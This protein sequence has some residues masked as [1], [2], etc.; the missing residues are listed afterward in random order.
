MGLIND[1]PEHKAIR[2]SVAGIAKRYG[3]GY[4][5]ERARTGGG[6]DELWNDLGA[7]GLLG[8]H[9]PEDYGGGGGSKSEAEG[10]VEELAAQ[11]MPL[12]IW[13]ISP[14]ICGS[15][16]ACHASDEMKQRWLPGIA[17][18]TKKMA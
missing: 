17:D 15:I 13:V 2:E 12:L 18:G 5:L 3:P 8:L 9:L 14:A 16:L 4:F 11:G 10:V 7:A 6:I 1:P